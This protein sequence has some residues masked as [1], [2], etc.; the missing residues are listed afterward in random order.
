MDKVQEELSLSEQLAA[1]RE[2]CERMDEYEELKRVYKEREA[3]ITAYEGEILVRLY[4]FAYKYLHFS[5]PQL[6]F[7]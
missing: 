6:A 7:A 5:A 3:L 2:A 4:S 1:A